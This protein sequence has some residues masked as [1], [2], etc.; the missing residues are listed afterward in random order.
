M[1]TRT[2]MICVDGSENSSRAFDKAVQFASRFAHIELLLVHIIRQ[3][4]FNVNDVSP[5]TTELV[6][7]YQIQKDE[8]EDLLNSYKQKC[9]EAKLQCTLL[10]K[11]TTSP[12]KNEILKQ[13]DEHKPS[14]VIVGCRGLSPLKSLVLGSV[15]EFIINNATCNILI[16]H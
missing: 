13:I 14:V 3:E 10:V 7:D 2:F 5:E 1:A 9:V 4:A 6:Q 11:E 15:S 16:V 12:I 8:A